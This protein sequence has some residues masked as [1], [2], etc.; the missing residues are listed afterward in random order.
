M[1]NK[2]KD[3]ICD[4]TGK[5]DIKITEASV[6]RSDL[7]L[8]SYDLVQ[9]ECK[10]EDVYDVEIRNIEKTKEANGVVVMN[11]DINGDYEEEIKIR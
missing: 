11:P 9:L 10:I 6:I 8:S 3:I 2:L 5:Q 1:I 7:G 4:Y